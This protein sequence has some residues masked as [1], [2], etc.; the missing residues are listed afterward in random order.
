MLPF[1]G[2]ARICAPEQVLC[3]GDEMDLETR[4]YVD[5]HEGEPIKTDDI[6]VDRREFWVPSSGNLGGGIRCFVRYLPGFG[7]FAA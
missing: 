3:R 6:I 2:T 5:S 1:N 7:S 4:A